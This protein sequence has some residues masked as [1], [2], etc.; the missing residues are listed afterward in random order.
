MTTLELNAVNATPHTAHLFYVADEA[1]PVRYATIAP[2]GR[3]VQETFEGHRWRLACEDTE[4]SAEIVMPAEAAE[5]RI[6]A[7]GGSTED[8]TEGAFYRQSLDVGVAGLRVRAAEVVSADAVRSAAEIVGKMLAD[9]PQTLL[10][11]LEA[12]MC[13]I[14]VIGREQ[15]TSDIPEHRAWA[16][17]TKGVLPPPPPP[18]PPL[19]EQREGELPACDCYCTPCV[20]DV[21]LASLNWL[22]DTPV[23]VP[24][25]ASSP[26][27]AI[28]SRDMDSTTRGLGG[29]RCTSV[30]EEN[31]ASDI[32]SD[33][34]Y[35]DES[36]LVHEFGHTVMNVG[37]GEEERGLVRECFAQAMKSGLYPT[38]SYMG[39]CADE[40]WA[41][42]SPPFAP[43]PFTPDA[44]A[45]LSRSIRYTYSRP[46]TDPITNSISTPTEIIPPPTERIPPQ[47][48]QS[49]TCRP[50]A[51]HRLP[52]RGSTRRCVMMSTTASTRATS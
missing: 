46:S 13:T 2:R 8:E 16:E 3:Q 4:V 25:P 36:I 38:S 31:L 1:E 43:T 10:A 24:P 41:E 28:E 29:A 45:V 21:V 34:F 9:S 26:G 52:N 30:G 49:V 20:A 37:M 35:R 33:P 50:A 23:S 17:Q 19:Q 32:A 6:D 14:A 44:S 40:Y 48:T 27:P 22:P 47:P 11:R 51:S 5:L 18:P 42:V 15:K 12:A 39:S 7:P